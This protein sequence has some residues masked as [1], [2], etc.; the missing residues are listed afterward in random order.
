MHHTPDRTMP[1]YA[2]VIAQSRLAFFP[3][4]VATGVFLCLIRRFNFRIRNFNLLIRT[5]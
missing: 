4:I 5:V 1:I 2:A 3:L